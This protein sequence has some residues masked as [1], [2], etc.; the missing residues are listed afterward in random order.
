MSGEASLETRVARLEQRVTDLDDKVAAVMPLA[1]DVALTKDRL[2][3]LT[4][5]FKLLVQK[6]DE[7]DE[8]ARRERRVYIRW[9][10][11]LTIT[12]ICAL[13]G[14]LAVVLSAGGHP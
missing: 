2:E 1:T 4:R 6:I 7:R 3:S 5:E 9:A 14:A 8:D 12:I 10:I 11:T 13:V